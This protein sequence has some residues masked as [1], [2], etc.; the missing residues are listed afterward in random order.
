MAGD[1]MIRWHHQLSGHEFGQTP[2]VSEGQESL[3]F[4]SP[5]GHKESDMT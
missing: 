1:E 2:G 3:A 5:P 4:C